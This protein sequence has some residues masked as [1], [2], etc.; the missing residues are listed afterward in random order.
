MMIVAAST[1]ALSGCVQTSP[2]VYEPSAIGQVA[3][4]EMGVVT[5][6]R[7]VE[8]AGRPGGTGIGAVVGA[9]A[10]GVAGA[11]IGPSSYSHRGHR[12]RY[13]SAGSALG[14]VGGALL[15]GLLGAAL[16]QEVTR[17]MAT[18]YTVQLDDGQM[19]TI[20]QGAQP[21]AAGQRVFLQ[22]PQRGRARIVPAA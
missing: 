18:E 22:T 1:V 15:G 3:Y 16:E 4:A 9:I 5:S 20:V 7:P 17:Q 12:H 14:S 10:G 8:V 13:T 2:N 19:I 6:A 21:I 11:Q